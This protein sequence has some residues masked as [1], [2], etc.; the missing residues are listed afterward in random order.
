[1]SKYISLSQSISYTID[2]IKLL[3]DQNMAKKIK[4]DCERYLILKPNKQ[5]NVNQFINRV[6]YNYHHDFYQLQNDVL[7]KISYNLAEDIKSISDIKRISE[8]IY[9]DLLIDNNHSNNKKDKAISFKPNKENSRTIDELKL[10][11]IQSIAIYIRNMLSKFFT[12]RSNEREIILYKAEYNALKSAI[13]NKHCVV[14][15]IG[16]NTKLFLKPYDILT[17]NESIYNYLIGK[18]YNKETKTYSIITQR[19]TRIKKVTI[20]FRSTVTFTNDDSLIIQKMI[21]NGVQFKYDE[22]EKNIVVTFSENGYKIFNLTFLQ[23]PL[24]VK[25]EYNENNKTY[26]LV[27]DC[28]YFQAKLFFSR[29]G[30]DAQIIEPKELVDYFADFYNK[31]YLKHKSN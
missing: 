31:A 26:T 19:L 18:Q 10:N 27:F 1:M 5:P 9:N 4:E 14:I 7:C 11:G 3:I 23:K 17:N 22:H 30:K 25:E 6:F 15:T 12:L 29:F 2:P 21:K 24:P 8:N 16:N 28:S 13:N 20:D